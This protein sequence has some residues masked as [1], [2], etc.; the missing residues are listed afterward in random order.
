MARLGRDEGTLNQPGAHR[1]VRHDEEGAQPR[2]DVEPAERELVT[3]APVDGLPDRIPLTVD[4]STGFYFH[5]E[6]QGLVF[7]GREPTIE[8]VASHGTRRRT[9]STSRSGVG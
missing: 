1:E 5:R 9:I 8:G 6:G 4:F 2:E 3:T 7:G